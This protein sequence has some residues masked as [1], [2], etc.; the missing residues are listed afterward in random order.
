M[1]WIY[2]F[3]DTWIESGKM[4]ISDCRNPYRYAETCSNLEANSIR[5]RCS[6]PG[7][8]RSHSGAGFGMLPDPRISRPRPL[9]GVR[10]TSSYLDGN[11]LER[12]RPAPSIGKQTGFYRIF[13]EQAAFGP[14]TNA[15]ERHHDK[16]GT[17]SCQ[18]GSPLSGPRR[19]PALYSPG[20][21][22][23][24]LNISSEASALA[25]LSGTIF[26]RP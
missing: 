10:Y 18:S 6:N 14:R 20:N 22:M 25:L 15:L 1:W 23:G 26:L 7:S 8:I 11:R 24:S 16:S 19:W 3:P 12:R 17:I 13:V 9:T 4:N 5:D 21:R 2:P